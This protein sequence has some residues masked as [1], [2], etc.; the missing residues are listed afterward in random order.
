MYLSLTDISYNDQ[1]SAAAF[2]FNSGY[3]LISCCFYW[4]TYSLQWSVTDMWNGRRT[5]TSCSLIWIFQTLRMKVV[6][7]FSPPHWTENVS[8]T[9]TFFWWPSWVDIECR[10]RRNRPMVFSARIL[11]FHRRCLKLQPLFV[12]PFEWRNAMALRRKLSGSPVEVTSP[13]FR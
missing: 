8:L 6:L 11:N 4:F 2:I 10:L 5:E 9:P 7:E 1:L 13:T 12:A 3:K